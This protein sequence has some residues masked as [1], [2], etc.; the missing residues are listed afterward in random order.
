MKFKEKFTEYATERVNPADTVRGGAKIIA[1]GLGMLALSVPIA[2]DISDTRV[3][4]CIVEIDGANDTDAL[5][6]MPSIGLPAFPVIEP[7]YSCPSIN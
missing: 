3:D 2:A 5:L 4:L 1:I 6:D 7:N